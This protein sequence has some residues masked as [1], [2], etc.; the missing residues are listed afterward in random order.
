MGA[1]D[2]GGDLPCAVCRYNLRGLSVRAACPECG[3]PVGTTILT[4]VD[5]LAEELALLTRPRVSASALVGA[6]LTGL[7]AAFALWAARLGDIAH[8]AGAGARVPF[9]ADIA[10][11]MLALCAVCAVFL[12]RPHARTPKSYTLR[13]WC[14]VLAFVPLIGVQWWIAE[15]VDATLPGSFLSSDG[16]PPV[17]S[18][19]RMGWTLSAVLVLLGLRPVARM[20]SYRSHLVR[21]GVIE[22]Q[23]MLATVSAL[24]VAATGDLLHV[25]APVAAPS[26]WAESINL[27]ALLIIGVGSMLTTLAV[28]AMLVDTVR[29]WPVLAHPPVTMT[30][31]QSGGHKA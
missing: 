3:L 20:L 24:G 23:T 6:M 11:A 21:N 19:L 14:G 27:I 28:G 31:L 2:L 4:R 17:R 26:A 13:A 10:H 9:A 15:R 18:L 29:L 16:P 25:L 1:F 7:L 12:T 30:S 22:R 5:P 8:A